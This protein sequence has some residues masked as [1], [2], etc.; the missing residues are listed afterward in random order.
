[1]SGQNRIN[2]NTDQLESITNRATN[3]VAREVENASYENTEALRDIANGG[4]PDPI[5]F[6]SMTPTMVTAPN[7]IEDR[8][9]PSPFDDGLNESVDNVASSIDNLS[10]SFDDYHDHLANEFKEMRIED[11]AKDVSGLTTGVLQQLFGGFDPA[12]YVF[13]GAVGAEIEF[14]KEMRKTAFQVEG[15]TGNLRNMQGEFAEIGKVMER[16]GG[17]TVDLSKFQQIY[18]KTLKKGYKKQKDTLDVVSTSLNLSNMIGADAEGT[19]DL[20]YE[21]Y[22]HTGATANE[23]SQLS[24]NIQDVARRTKI[25]GN[26][27]MQAVKASEEFATN[28]KNARNFSTDTMDN[29]IGLTAESQKLGIGEDTGKIIKAATSFANLIE[30][31][32]KTQALLFSAASS[33]GKSE[34]LTSGRMMSSKDNIKSLSKGF[35]NILANFGYSVADLDKLSDRQRENLNVGLKSGFGVE[36][37]AFEKLIDATKKQSQTMA[38]SIKEIDNELKNAN[39]T[40]EEVAKLEKDR[41]NT[42]KNSG[43]K[44]LTEFDKRAKNA[45]SFDEAASMASMEINK[46]KDKKEDLSYLAE[47][48]NMKITSDADMFKVSAL[49][50]AKELKTKSNGEVDFTN[51]IEDAFASKDISKVRELL[52]KMNSEDQILSSQAADA[53]DPII[54]LGREV[55]VL[56]ETLRGWTGPIVG[57]IVDFIGATGLLSMSIAAFVV[58]IVTSVD[59]LTSIFLKGFPRLFKALGKIPGAIGS[60]SLIHI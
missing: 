49:A 27:L 28:L 35:E 23:M 39:L 56:N 50:V 51:Q 48:M 44:F 37:G 17:S 33:V 18:T 4:S 9:A 7:R 2:R 11:R 5:G 20:F 40:A 3:S 14:R 24:R 52:T 31:D 21:W 36:L 26:E 43:F 42:L 15:I 34:E 41:A 57:A 30:A 1:M 32:G 29:I 19:S 53:V 8:V 16:A 59:G 47:S 55:R 60:L 12:Q 58:S 6:G 22:Q 10:D 54:E 45:T 38:E 13:S 46:S 25:T